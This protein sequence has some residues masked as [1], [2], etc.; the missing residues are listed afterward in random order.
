MQSFSILDFDSGSSYAIHPYTMYIFQI[1][2]QFVCF[3]WTKYQN[4]NQQ[5]V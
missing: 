2:I 3:I 5:F 1:N 4:W